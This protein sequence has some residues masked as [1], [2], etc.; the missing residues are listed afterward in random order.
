MILN[1]YFDASYMSAGKGQSRAGGYFFLGSIPQ[2]G[3]S[4]QLNGNIVIT[5]AI[6]KLVTVSAAENEYGALFVNTK[7][8]QVICLLLVKLG[9]P[10][11]PTQIRIN[12]KTAV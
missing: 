2:N 10:Q 5:C 7:E 9:H 1:V 3:E 4:I 12:N 8:A 6:L 11:P